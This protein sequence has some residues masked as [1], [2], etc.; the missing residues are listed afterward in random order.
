MTKIKEKNFISA[1]VYVHNAED[2]ISNFM[3]QLILLLENNFDHSEIVCVNDF[4]T[5]CSVEKI[6]NIRNDAKETA[7]SIVNLSHFHGLEVA[8]NAGVDLSIGD[9]VLEIDTTMQTW[10]DAVVMQ[11]YQ[12][13]LEGND[14]VSAS[15]DKPQKLSSS[16]FYW[17]YDR[18]SDSKEKMHSETFRILS[19]RAVNRI[20]SM[21]RTVPYRK[22]IYTNCGLQ[23]ANI[24]YK[25][26]NSKLSE[27]NDSQLSSYRNKLAFETLVLFTNA[28]YFVTKF[29]T[30][31]MIFISLFMIVYTFVV[32][33]SKHPVEGWT[34][35]ILFLSVAFLGL[36][37]ILTIIV[38][39]LQIL[40]E[41]NFKRT[42]YNFASIEKLTK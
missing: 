19:R 23:T 22:G 39:Y 6:K 4:S 36:F 25:V 7:I 16:I 8:M 15:P 14:I 9:F 1:V 28:G 21:S 17:L 11:V 34:T 10:D 41:L 31:L 35:T 12:K 40:V 24:K 13:V 30:T 5:D 26:I 42:K 33:L 37:A 18:F 3:K 29:M 20:N 27:E 32:Y 38:K 2:R